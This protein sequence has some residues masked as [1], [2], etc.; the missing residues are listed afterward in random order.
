[1]PRFIIV[2][3]VALIGCAS[4][5]HAAWPFSDKKESKRPEVKP[6]PA[7]TSQVKQEP[8]AVERVRRAH[9]RFEDAGM[10]EESCRRNHGGIMEEES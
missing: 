3:V 4:Y 10:E 1:M 5:S 2:V 8:A 9:L 7:E 6:P